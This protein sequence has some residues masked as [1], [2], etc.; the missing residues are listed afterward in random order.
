M[1][2]LCL[3]LY[4]R[5]EDRVFLYFV[6]RWQVVNRPSLPVVMLKLSAEDGHIFEKDPV[7]TQNILERVGVDLMEIGAGV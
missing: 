7:L 5:W 4:L 1:R 6:E 2:Q 3:G